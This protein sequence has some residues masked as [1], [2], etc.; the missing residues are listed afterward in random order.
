MKAGGHGALPRECG[1]IMSEGLTRYGRGRQARHM[2]D[3][4]AAGQ[5][6]ALKRILAWLCLCLG[7]GRAGCGGHRRHT[8]LYDVP[9]RAGRDAAGKKGRVRARARGLC[10][11]EQPPAHLH[12]GRR[13]RRGQALL[14]AW[15]LRRHQHR[16]RRSGK[17]AHRHAVGGAALP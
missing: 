14:R 17:P 9:G 5:M 12:T 16:P 7:G 11:A 3:R 6:K 4:K 2:A 1:S 13:G 10:E 15:R 8:G